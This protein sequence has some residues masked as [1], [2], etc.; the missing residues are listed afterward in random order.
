[1][2]T[3]CLTE[4][5]VCLVKWSELNIKQHKSP[6]PVVNGNLFENSDRAKQKITDQSGS[7]MLMQGA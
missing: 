7:L 1:M 3:S 6:D 4:N 2:I 5:N